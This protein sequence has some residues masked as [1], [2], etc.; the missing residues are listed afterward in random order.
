MKTK[1]NEAIKQVLQQFGEKYFIGE[2]LN[3][4][5][6]IQDL[7]TYDKDLLE[8]F[9]SNETIQSNF[10][11]DIAGNIVMQTNKLIELFEADE[12]WQ[13]S[14]TKYSKKIGLTADGKFIDEST[15]VVLDF[16]YKDTVLKASMSKEDTDKDDLR[17][18]EPFLNEVL[19][20][21]EIDV[22][23][24]KKILVNAKKFDVDGV[25]EI[26]SFSEDDNLI[27]KGNN[28][29]ALHTL[30]E[31]FSG[32]IKLIYIDPPY[33]TG[34]DGFDYNDKFNHSTWLTFMKNRLEIACELLCEEGTIWVQTD[35]VETN[36][37]GVLLDQVFDRNNFINIVTVKTKISGVS[38]SSEGK[39][40]RDATEFIQVYAKNKEKVYLNPVFEVT[41]VVEYVNE[42]K[43]SGKSWKY[44]QVLEE[45]GD[46][47]LI[48]NNGERAYYHYPNA[49]I[50]SIKQFAKSNN[51]TE[52]G[53]YNQFPEK[54]FR[55]TNAQSSVRGRVITDLKDIDSG[56]VS[57]EYKP[58]KGKS[59]NELIEIFYNGS[60]KDMF[61]FLSD[62]LV[63][64]KGKLMYQQKLSTLWEDIQYNNLKK[65]GQVDF[66]NGKKPEKLLKNII[67][68]A[69]DEGDI[70][71]DFFMG[72]GSTQAA[73]L[74]LGRKFIGMEQIDTQWN[75]AVERLKKAVNN[76]QSGISK[77]VD[78][79]GGGSFVYLELM[80]KN[81]GFLKTIQDTK[82]QAE[83]HDVFDFML[84][85]AEID[86]RVDL[87]KI[88]DTLHELSFDD[89]KKT[90]IKIIDKNQLY[91]N[92]SEIDDENVRDLISD[93]DYEFNK[94]FYDKGGE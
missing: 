32:K 83:L 25:H 49:K 45:L 69:S 65:E 81:R 10:T 56:I 64:V 76:D 61:M 46:R 38:G 48:D 68:L 33:N 51:L 3:K 75:K 35:D 85:E 13:D 43:E 18:E 94:N 88:K 20:K 31:K 53:V 8:A 40:L 11:I 30:K 6:V 36:Y 59:A 28:L 57:I 91:Y 84:N 9:I 24:D 23:L 86:F 2:I 52:E 39:S 77:E 78:W 90:L 70:V 42:Y 44:T 16:P 71:L 19:A 92:Y 12:Y 72:S 5:K 89:Q 50:T 15:D 1:I 17:P 29:L 66:P 73:A 47:I 58:I 22:L 60:N 87:E 21:E 82:T 4:N 93:N 80:E 79:Q 7:D 27:I 63:E 55:T 14:Y 26:E 37:L 74:K 54:I 34:N 67:E 62:R 41:P